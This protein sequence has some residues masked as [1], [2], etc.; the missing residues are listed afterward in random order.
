M[1]HFRIVLDYHQP[2]QITDYLKITFKNAGH[3]LGSAF[4]EIEIKIKNQWKTLIFSGDLGMT[5]RLIIKP[6]E[7]QKMGRLYL[8]VHIR[9]QET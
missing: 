1:E 9:K 4:V 3:I 8:R 7:F 2:Y 5:D 6:L